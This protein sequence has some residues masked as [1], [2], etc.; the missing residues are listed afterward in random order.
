MG[1]VSAV[2]SGVLSLLGQG[3]PFMFVILGLSIVA[4]TIVIAKL[5]QFRSRR[6][7][8]RKFI[9]PVLRTWHSRDRAAAVSQASRER[10][11]VGKVMHAAMQ[12]TARMQ[13]DRGTLGDEVQRFAR[14]QL[15]ALDAGMRG[16]ELVAF[17]APLCGL[18]GTIL[19]L[20]GIG[21]PDDGSGFEAALVSSAAGIALSIM[22]ALFYYVLDGRIERERRTMEQAVGS[23]LSAPSGRA[24]ARRQEQEVE[25]EE[26]EEEYEDYD[27]DEGYYEPEYR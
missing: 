9:A 23:I 8:R 11:P 24:P 14:E 16:L 1:T 25:Y 12:S 17:I 13:I 7:G 18:F 10:S 26:E 20:L 5:W 22:T 3:G 19:G 27:E 21:V 2:A 4:L 15:A 6:V